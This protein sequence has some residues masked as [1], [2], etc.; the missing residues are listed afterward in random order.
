MAAIFSDGI[1]YYKHLS[2]LKFLPKGVTDLN[3]ELSE[4]ILIHT[5]DTDDIG[6]SR[7]HQS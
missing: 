5:G 4:S 1:I 7:R 3:N 6:C 2:I